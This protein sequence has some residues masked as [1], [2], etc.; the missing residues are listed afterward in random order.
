MSS[1]CS[2][3]WEQRNLLCR[4]GD[5]AETQL[6]NFGVLLLWVAR[7]QG[8]ILIPALCT[9]FWNQGLTKTLAPS[10]CF[11][12]N[13]K[14]LADYSQISPA[15]TAFVVQITADPCHDSMLQ[16][17]SGELTAAEITHWTCTLVCGDTGTDQLC[18]HNSESQLSLEVLKQTDF[19]LK[20]KEKKI[21]VKLELSWISLNDK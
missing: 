19:H 15:Q 6:R 3:S 20:F 4:Q 17:D 5:R 11:F 14:A 10:L 16:V 21:M 7:S 2:S 12:F 9:A 13:T 18:L 8:R 1:L